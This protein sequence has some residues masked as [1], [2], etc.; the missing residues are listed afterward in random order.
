[1]FQY[2]SWY[3]PADGSLWEDVKTNAQN[4]ANLGVNSVWLPPAYKGTQGGMSSGY[5]VYDIYDLGEFDQ[6]GSVR[7]KFGTKQQ[8]KEAVESLH[9][10]GIQV[11]VDIVLNHRGGGD[12]TEKVT[13]RKVDPENRNNFISD[14]FEIEAFTKFTFPGRQGQY[15]QFVWD[16]RCFS[17]VDY[18]K[19]KEETAIFSIANEYG[20]GWQEVIDSEKGNYDFLMFADVEFRNSSVREE[21]KRWGEWYLKEIGFDGVRLDA[22]KHITP[23]FYNEWLDHMRSIKD[24]LFAVG[25]YW[26]PGELPLLQKYIDATQRRMSLFDASLHHN[27][28]HASNE[29][30]NFDLRKILDNSLVQADPALAV[31]VVDN[32]DTQPLQALE[33]PVEK[34]FKPLAY[35]LILLREA[36]YPCIFHPDLYGAHYV[37]KGND[38]NDHEIFLDK[39]PHIDELLLARKLYAYGLQRD[40]FDHANCIGWTREGISEVENSGCAILLSNGDEGF[41]HMEIGKQHAGKTFND[42]LK[43]HP[44]TVTIDENGWGEFHVSPGSVSVWISSQ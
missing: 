26:A 36:G 4:L 35:A 20:D 3:Y 27:F 7:T 37:D 17:D 18:A 30:N 44:A 8:Y 28:Y 2:F 33:A 19:D 42:L 5:D 39:C 6:K 1:M 16:F 25:E 12:E 9:K 14:A 32:H 10:A 23:A 34:W 11:Y 40:Y 31:T 41:K 15:S 13:V 38:G 22:V 24:D 21:L 29:G 43:Q